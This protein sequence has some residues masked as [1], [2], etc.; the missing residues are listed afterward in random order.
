MPRKIFL[1]AVCVILTGCATASVARYPNAQNI[2]PTNP[3][4]VSVYTNFPPVQYEIIGEIEG[5]G[6]QFASWDMVSDEMRKKAAEIGGDAVVIQVRDTPFV[7][8]INRPGTI[9]GNTY[10]H[11]NSPYGNYGGSG[12]YQSTSNY[13]YTPPSSTPMYGKYARGV[14]IKYKNSGNTILNY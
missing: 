12:I 4:N 7:G 6:D 14:V 5:S 10:G 2:P 1:L 8:A 3:A 9:Q 11:V 13:T